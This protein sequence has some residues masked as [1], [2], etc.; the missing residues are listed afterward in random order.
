MSINLNLS[1]ITKRRS[2]EILS[3]F[4]SIKTSV[5]QLHEVPVKK[6][7]TKA[8]IE[9]KK[10]TN[11]ADLD[12]DI[13]SI[14]N[15]DKKYSLISESLHHL[16]I[17]ERGLK[18]KH[19]ENDVS[20]NNGNLASV[21]VLNPKNKNLDD[22]LNSVFE[23]FDSTFLKLRR[24]FS[25]QKFVSYINSF[26]TPNS[27]GIHNQKQV[28]DIIALFKSVDKKILSVQN[29]Q[30]RSGI[31][32]GYAN[33]K[34]GILGSK[35]L[36]FI[37]VNGKSYS[38]NILVDSKKKSN[39]VIGVTENGETKHII[40]EPDGK[41]LKSKKINKRHDTGKESVYYMGNEVDSLFITESLRSLKSELVE[42]DK[43]VTRRLNALDA[44]RYKYSTDNIGIIKNTVMDKI[45]DM[46]EKRKLI[47]NA[48]K[49]LKKEPRRKAN[50]KLGIQLG[51]DK[52]RAGETALKIWKQK[53]LMKVKDHQIT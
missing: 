27:L 33:I 36:D 23:L 44:F 15:G 42:Y 20:I 47:T 40:V 50:E 4:N 19:I 46:R 5:K 2:S 35:Q 8:F 18:S 28:D 22:Y 32:N 24:N 3:M 37:D 26:L 45:I 17:V 29:P 16:R 38:V 39:L 52:F 13:I 10:H 14:K 12:S 48:M 34:K 30:T 43:Y 31:K 21:N 25:N 41:V 51:E 7:K 1:Y 49:W 11:L 9:I 6:S 53:Y